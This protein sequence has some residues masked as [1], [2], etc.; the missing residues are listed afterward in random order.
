MVL[1][2]MDI[3]PTLLTDPVFSKRRDL[4]RNPES[5]F[6]C[7]HDDPATLALKAAGAARVPNETV[8]TCTRDDSRG[9]PDVVFPFARDK[10]H[11]HIF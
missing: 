2:E 8:F 4:I 7:G 3:D 10:H 5:T 6:L 1:N 9:A 11:F